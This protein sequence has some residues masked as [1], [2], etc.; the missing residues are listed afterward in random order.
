MSMWFRQKICMKETV[1][2]WYIWESTPT[3]RRLVA[4][5]YFLIT[6]IQEWGTNVAC[7]FDYSRE[8]K[9]PHFLRD[10]SQCLNHAVGQ[11]TSN[12]LLNAARSHQFKKLV[13]TR[14]ADFLMNILA[15]LKLLGLI[16]GAF[17][18]C[19]SSLSPVVLM[20]SATMG[21][22]VL[23]D[24]PL[25][26]G[27]FT[28]FVAVHVERTSQDASKNHWILSLWML[29]G[30]PGFC[31]L[32]HPLCLYVNSAFPKFCSLESPFLCHISSVL[33]TLWQ[34]LV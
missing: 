19:I 14:N 15:E 8:H 29:L 32:F 27:R 33:L 22:R 18:Y 13:C 16:L 10:F 26:S 21:R 31:F 5:Q 28:V 23:S 3:L 2:L 4:M 24:D 20:A 6:A 34:R 25:S 17:S 12:L 30:C 7:S 9:N 11:K 1:G